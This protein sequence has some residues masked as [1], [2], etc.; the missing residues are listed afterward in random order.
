[1]KAI[2]TI[3]AI[4][5]LLFGFNFY[6]NHFYTKFDERINNA[7][8][9]AESVN[10]IN[11]PESATDSD[12]LLF[13]TDYGLTVFKTGY[14]YYFEKLLKN[15]GYDFTWQ[16]TYNTIPHILKGDFIYE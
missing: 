9:T 4:V 3:A 7:E 16:N 11:T 10:N 1:M 5:V 12:S 6:L 13:A 15:S 8:Q 2:R 14:M